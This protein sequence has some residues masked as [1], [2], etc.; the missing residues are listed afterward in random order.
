M[1]V[2]D[3]Q[4]KYR[5]KLNNI[6]DIIVAF[7]LG[8]LAFSKLSF[9]VTVNILKF[10]IYF[11]ELF[12][13]IF[14]ILY[15]KNMKKLTKFFS[16]FGN[17]TALSLLFF[18][19]CFL[20]MIAALNGTMFEVLST[21][22]PILYIIIFAFI[23]PALIELTDIV[24][25][26]FLTGV[27]CGEL[28]YILNFASVYDLDF[29]GIEAVNLIAVFS[30][31]S[32]PILARMWKLHIFSLL[33]VIYLIFCSGFRIV[34]FT[35]LFALIISYSIQLYR[36]RHLSRF[37]I[38]GI[39]SVSSLSIFYFSKHLL[40]I[41]DIDRF[42]YFRIVDRTVALISGDFLESQDNYRF[43][44]LL[45]ALRLEEFKIFPTGFDMRSA[46]KVGNLNDIPFQY[47]LDTFGAP[48]GIIVITTIII[49]G[50]KYCFSIIRKPESNSYEMLSAAF[51]PFFILLLF[52][53]GRF[54]Y[55]LYESIMFGLL[56]GLWFRNNNCV[57]AKS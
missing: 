13:F 57:A 4:M 24:F 27:I 17:I 1:H 21:A 19:W 33:L 26:V 52:V 56:I 41:L 36:S 35:V 22:R 9:A 51:F 5:F 3:R 32:L 47:F 12:L 6:F 20:V 53:N 30:Y 15:I 28:I 37:K 40:N 42:A 54:L 39:L 50:V 11:P 8:A 46:G 14:F 2:Y 45:P 23:S 31:I 55:I 29:R 38:I 34:I 16:S 49:F 25:F 10:P 44:N 18:C 43:N 48:V 7:F